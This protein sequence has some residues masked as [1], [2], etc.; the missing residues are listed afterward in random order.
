MFALTIGRMV[1]TFVQSILE[2]IFAKIL[3]NPAFCAKL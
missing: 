1:Y 2:R 3:T